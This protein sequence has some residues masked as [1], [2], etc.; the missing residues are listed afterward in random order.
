VAQP[1]DYRIDVN[2]DG[3]RTEVTVW[4]GRGEVTG[5][6]SSFTVVAGQFASFTGSGNVADHL[7]YDHGQIP[8]QDGFDSWASGRDRVED[9]SA[10]ANYVSR[11]MT[12]YEDLDGNGNWSYVAGYG[13]A[14]SPTGVAAGWAPYRFGHWAWVGPWGW[15]WVEDEPWGFAP[16]HY[17]RWAFAGGAWMWVPGRAWCADVYA[18]LGGL[19]RRPAR[20][21]LLVRC[22]SGVVSAGSGRSI[23]SRL[24]REPRLCEQRELHQYTGERRDGHQPLQ[25]RGY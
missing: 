15:T 23:Y 19:G 9:Q 1:G 24:P 8:D 21:Q 22:G 12:G 13:M 7:D 16:F 17:G 2:E 25:H 4:R 14:W 20:I 11:D 6:G 10:S 3:S 5:G 18:G